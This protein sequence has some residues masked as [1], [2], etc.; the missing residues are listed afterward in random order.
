MK[1]CSSCEYNVDPHIEIDQ[2]LSTLLP[3]WILVD[4]VISVEKLSNYVVLYFS[5]AD[6]HYLFDCI[7]I[8][9]KY[10]VNK[11]FLSNNRPYA[12]VYRRLLSS[13][14]RTYG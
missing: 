3:F 1:V 12:G 7:N 11:S 5:L 13:G 6:I 4:N 10:N 8:F 14:N 2:D 9:Q